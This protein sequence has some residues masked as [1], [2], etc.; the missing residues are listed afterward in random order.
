MEGGRHCARGERLSRFSSDV[1][2]FT[3]LNPESAAIYGLFFLRRLNQASLAMMRA[4]IRRERATF[5]G[6]WDLHD[7]G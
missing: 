7:D 3:I 2:G 6:S 5:P 4:M 1:E